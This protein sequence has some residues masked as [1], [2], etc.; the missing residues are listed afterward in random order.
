MDPPNSHCGAPQG[1][2]P[3]DNAK[4]GAGAGNDDSDF[5]RHTPP[6]APEDE[7]DGGGDEDDEGGHGTK[8]KMD[9][10]A[11]WMD[12]N[13][14]GGGEEGRSSVGAAKEA[15]GAVARKP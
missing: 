8:E 12:H 10:V 6:R 14:S 3:K 9:M 2:G 11:T 5:G 7:E 1:A 4:D 15:D 13:I